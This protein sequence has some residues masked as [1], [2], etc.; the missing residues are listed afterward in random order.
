MST[1]NINLN[2]THV[3]KRIFLQLKFMQKC[4]ANGK[5]IKES[6]RNSIDLTRILLHVV[7]VHR[8]EQ[9]LAK[10]NQ[11]E[12][13]STHFSRKTAYNS[14]AYIMRIL[15]MVKVSQIKTIKNKISKMFGHIF[16]KLVYRD[17]I[18]V[19]SAIK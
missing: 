19:F 3:Y 13:I 14:E 10:N 12:P 15:L 2:N 11:S 1:T 5:K 4:Q 9:Y 16:K 17:Y 18:N 7:L 8:V 6:T